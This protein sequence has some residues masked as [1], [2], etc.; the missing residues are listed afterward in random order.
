MIRDGQ[1]TF[2]DAQAITASAAS[3]N[4]IDLSIDRDMGVG[5]ELYIVTVVVVAF[6][7]AGSNST[8]TVTAETDTTAAFG[9]ATTAQTLFTIP[10]LAAVGRVDVAR[11]QP[12]ATDERFL[13]LFYTATNGDLTTGSVDA[14]ITTNADLYRFHAKGYTITNPV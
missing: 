4:L 8:I 5:T 6:T 12:F 14:F 10:A 3:T 9:S 11:F 1:T 7:D 2:S 13:R